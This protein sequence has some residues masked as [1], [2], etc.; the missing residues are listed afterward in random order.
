MIDGSLHVQCRAWVLTGI[1]LKSKIPEKKTKLSSEDKKSWDEFLKN[2]SNILDK[3]AKE[4]Q[5]RKP[6]RY[7]FDLH[8]ISINEANKKVSEII[9][10]CYD[11]GFSEILLITGKGHHSKSG[12]NVYVSRNF[13]TLKG[14]IPEFIKS[15]TSLSSKILKMQTAPENEGGEGALIIK[16]KNSLK[17]K[18][19]QIGIFH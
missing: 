15:N 14:T 2:P 6:K 18:F 13:S 19:W 1:F 7:K 9:D 10:K 17:N 5:K 3:E 12:E 11:E 4:I 16:L 8:G